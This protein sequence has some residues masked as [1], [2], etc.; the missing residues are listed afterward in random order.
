MSAVM[1]EE[2]PE[3][4]FE[5]AQS[6]GWQLKQLKPMHRDVCAFLAQ[7]MKHVQV[8]QLCG[9][10]PQYI[11]ML[12]GQDLIKQEIQ[13]IALVAGTRLEAMF[14]KSVDVIADAMQSGSH[15]DK[16]KA[17]RLQLEA[18]KRIGRPDA[19]AGQVAPDEDRLA[20][21]AER[22]IGLRSTMQMRADNENAESVSYKEVGMERGLLEG[23][24]SKVTE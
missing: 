16:L 11:T 18:T 21:L 22:L 24:F 10:T 9:I 20:K 2:F 5:V 14:E 7:G 12:C 13:R 6:Q 19:N 23:S 1:Q 3:S 4:D 15:S 8:A 17:A